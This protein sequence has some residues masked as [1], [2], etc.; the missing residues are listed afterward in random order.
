VRPRRHL[1]T[2]HGVLAPAASLRSQIVPGADDEEEEGVS[3]ETAS[4][5]T[6]LRWSMQAANLVRFVLAFRIG[7]SWRRRRPKLWPP[8]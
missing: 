7:L 2:Y 4:K 5:V 6:S 3:A 8:T 1:V